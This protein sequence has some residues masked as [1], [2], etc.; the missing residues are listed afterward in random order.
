MNVVSSFK[1]QNYLIHDKD[2]T[3]K[4]IIDKRNLFLEDEEVA[5]L[6]ITPSTLAEQTHAK[7]TE[8]KY[9]QLMISTITHDLKSPIM[10]IQGHLSVL[11]NYV[12]DNGKQ[13]LKAAQISAQAF[14]YYIYDLVVII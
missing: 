4:Y 14:E 12:I 5:L 9:S 11:D 6:S 3:L 13:Y 7:V 10:A 1:E 8:S 2:H